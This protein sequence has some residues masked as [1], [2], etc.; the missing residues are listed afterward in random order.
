MANLL[1]ASRESDSLR[2]KNPGRS[3]PSR[4]LVLSAVLTFL[5]QRQNGSNR[6][7]EFCDPADDGCRGQPR[8]PCRVLDQGVLPLLEQVK[9]RSEINGSVVHPIMLGR[10]ALS[11]GKRAQCGPA[12]RACLSEIT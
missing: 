2:S 11:L 4:G 9:Q 1:F 10:T 7:L 8:L 5:D 12:L 6:V 3:Q